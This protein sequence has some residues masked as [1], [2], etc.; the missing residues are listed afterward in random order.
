MVAAINARLFALPF[1]KTSNNSIFRFNGKY[2]VF[3][4]LGFVFVEGFLL[5]DY[6]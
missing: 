5:V 2:N 4:Y 6:R 1:H 3:S